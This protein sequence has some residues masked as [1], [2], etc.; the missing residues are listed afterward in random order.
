MKIEK[1]KYQ[2][3]LWYSDQKEP[4][5]FNNELFELEIADNENPFIVE[6]QLYDE[7]NR[8]SISI[9]YVDGNY[10]VNKYKVKEEDFNNPSFSGS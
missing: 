7:E 6:G 4:K 3:Y 9:K 2:G 8:A 1:S 5:V 10:I